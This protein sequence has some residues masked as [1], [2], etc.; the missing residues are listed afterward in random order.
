[1]AKKKGCLGCSLPVAIILV[2]LVLATVVMGLLAGPLGRAF[3]IEGLPSW[4]TLDTPH[5]KL[6][7]DV[8]FNLFGF[9]PVTNTLIATWI[10]IILLSFVFWFAFKKPKMV[11]GKL[12]SALEAALGWVYDICVSTAGERD[13]R[14]FFPFVTTLFLFI[15]TSAWLALVPGFASIVVTYSDGSH[16]EFLRSTGTDLSTTL[17]LALITFFTVEII[18]FKRLGFGYL[19][20]F[21][22]FGGLA[23]GFKMLFSKENRGKAGMAIVT[24]FM[25]AFAGLLELVSELV[26]ILSLSFRLFG[27]MLA[28]EILL[29]M[30]AFLIPYFL[31][32]PFYGLELLVGF[33]QALVFASLAIVYLSVAVTPHAEEH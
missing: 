21:F 7:A 17:A 27:N 10:T 23:K 9:I 5:I 24:G 19:K 28:G 29:L 14:R 26:R 2:V 20:K 6:P 22:V 25:T 15:I 12:Q 8:L 31:P 33:I 18:G 13:G 30:M 16:G 4:M 11:P 32:L 3:G 1:M